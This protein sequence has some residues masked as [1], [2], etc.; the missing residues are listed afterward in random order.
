M[1]ACDKKYKCKFITLF[2]YIFIFCID[3]C[4][5]WVYYNICKEYLQNTGR[6]VK[7][8]EEEMTINTDIL[9]RLIEWLRSQG[10]SDADITACIEF[11]TKK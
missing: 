5:H 1:T 11:I 9:N 10:H 6:E 4:T 8:M 2:I 3:F 7:E